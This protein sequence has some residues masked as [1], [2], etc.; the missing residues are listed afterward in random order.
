MAYPD[1][2]RKQSVT[3]GWTP[4][5]IAMK[6]GASKATVVLLLD[7][8]P[9]AARLPAAMGGFLPLH[10]AMQY[11]APADATL[12]LYKA[13]PV[14]V[15]AESQTGET[16]LDLDLVALWTALLGH[17]DSAVVS[18]KLAKLGAENK[19]LLKELSKMKKLNGE[20]R[21]RNNGLF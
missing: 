21:L 11:H 19:E 18:D 9:D 17:G 10:L 7:A 2:A 3:S 14:A 5:H 20:L 12:A 8:Y 16:P 15:N 4:L 13:W 6:Q 1:A